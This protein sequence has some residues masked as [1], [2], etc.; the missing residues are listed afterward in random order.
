MVFDSVGY[1]KGLVLMGNFFYWGKRG[2][3]GAKWMCDFV[4]LQPMSLGA[5]RPLR[6]IE[7]PA[8]LQG[9]SVVMQGR[10]KAVVGNLGLAAHFSAHLG[11]PRVHRVLCST[12]REL[13]L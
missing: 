4:T 5:G 11:Q 6:E 1:R 13:A 8:N 12:I 3:R 7:S 9:G 2:G 10:F